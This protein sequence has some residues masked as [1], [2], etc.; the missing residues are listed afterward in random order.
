MTDEAQARLVNFVFG[1]V[2]YIKR[3]R[4]AYG[5]AKALQV[6][7]QDEIDVQM[8]TYT[9]V[10]TASN[11]WIN[12]SKDYA[13]E[14]V[15]KRLNLVVHK[16]YPSI[17]NLKDVEAK[18]SLLRAKALEVFED[19][20]LNDFGDF[21]YFVSGI[22]GQIYDAYLM[23]SGRDLQYS[24]IELIESEDGGLEMNSVATM[25]SRRA[26]NFAKAVAQAEEKAEI[27]ALNVES[28][29]VYFENKPNDLVKFTAIRDR[30]VAE[31]G[32]ETGKQE[33]GALV[34]HAEAVYLYRLRDRIEAFYRDLQEP[35]TVEEKT[36]TRRASKAEQ[37]ARAER[38]RAKARAVAHA[39]TVAE[40]TGASLSEY[41][42][43]HV[44]VEALADLRQC[45]NMRLEALRLER[46]SVFAP[47]Y[48]KYDLKDITE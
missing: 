4:I 39:Y 41:E 35:L 12:G 30:V 8:D 22:C 3:K 38:N 9:R 17:K 31:Q 5:K 15:E 36:S 26:V 14:Q 25:L 21:K 10:L 37:E 1:M 28:L 11:E 48:A 40:Y 27:L 44:R 42:I 32:T 16:A 34:S 29:S 19:F 33:I 46:E 7:E 23:N 47:R 43:D 24:S 2:L 18:K 6:I 13:F 45:Q 20:D